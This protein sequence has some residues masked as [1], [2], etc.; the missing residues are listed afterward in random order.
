MMIWNKKKINL[1]GKIMRGNVIWIDEY[2]IIIII[3]KIN[4]ND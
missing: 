2:V 1:I 3:L 4:L